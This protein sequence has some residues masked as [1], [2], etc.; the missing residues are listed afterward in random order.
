[1]RDSCGEE[2]DM[3]GHALDELDKLLKA[4]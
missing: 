1:M 4:Y 2:Q 3:D